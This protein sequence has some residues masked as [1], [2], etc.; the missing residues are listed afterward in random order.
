MSSRLNMPLR[1]TVASPA[2]K[3]TLMV[4]DVI[5][6]N[7]GVRGVD[8]LYNMHQEG[9]SLSESAFRAAL[10]RLRQD[11]GGTRRIANVDG[12]WYLDTPFAAQGEGSIEP[13]ASPAYLRAAP[14]ARLDAV[15]RH[16]SK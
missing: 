5:K 10:R 4:F 8:L 11:K 16:P 14:D 3:V 6:R 12:K 13:S 9:F 2:F 15:T 7:P 1:Q